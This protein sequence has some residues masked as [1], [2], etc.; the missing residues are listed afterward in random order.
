MQGGRTSL[1]HTRTRARALTPTEPQREKA[2]TSG[3]LDPSTFSLGTKLSGDVMPFCTAF[4]LLERIKSVWLGLVFPLTAVLTSQKPRA[5]PMRSV[6][7]QAVLA[8]HAPA[9]R[10]MYFGSTSGK[11]CAVLC[12][13]VWVRD[14]SDSQLAGLRQGARQAVRHA[15][16]RLSGISE[17]G[18]VEGL[19]SASRGVSSVFQPMTYRRLVGLVKVR[20][21]TVG[22]SH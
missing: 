9:L 2:K 15:A 8:R 20:H 13:P 22:L 10:A 7:L 11:V 3:T 18:E 5:M 16:E 14:V 21:P 6:E 19:A 1:P 4:S 12:V 17:H